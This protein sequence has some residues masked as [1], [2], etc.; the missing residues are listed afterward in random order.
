MLYPL[1]P[2]FFLYPDEAALTMSSDPNCGSIV[3]RVSH[4][5]VVFL[6]TGDAE[7]R[8]ESRLLEFEGGNLH[9]EKW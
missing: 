9:R 2:Q 8:E 1:L 3:L 5:D 6:L 4:G 7:N